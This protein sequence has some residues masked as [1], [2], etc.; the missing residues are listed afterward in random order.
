[1]ADPDHLRILSEGVDAWN[2]WRAEHLQVTPDLTHA[3]LRGADLR[4]ADL[5]K[6]NLSGA[7]LY[8]AN[9]TAA[10][11]KGSWLTAANLT[12]AVL[13]GANLIGAALDFAHLCR[14]DLTRAE[15]TPEGPPTGLGSFLDLAT[16]EGLDLATFSEPGFLPTYVARA[17]QYAHTPGTGDAQQWPTFIKVVLNRIKAV[18][19]LY[20]GIEPPRLI[21][22]VEAIT[23]ELIKYLARHPRA[24][25]RIGP[26]QF[27]EL[28]AEILASYGWRVQLTPASKDGGYDLFA[29]SKDASGLETSWIIECKKYKPENKVGVDIAR[30]LYGV[31]TDLSVSTALLATTSDF[32]RGVKAYKASHYDLELRDYEGILEWINTYRPNP[33]GRLYIKDDRL[34]LPGDKP[35]G[36]AARHCGNT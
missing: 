7:S 30:A 23:A 32:T 29:I 27:E 21:E 20:A 9:L 34:I 28:I 1:M 22:A 26:R 18:R 35:P 3:D 36:Q 17:F 15:F 31:K 24:L 10:N 33:D 11:L 14:A 5:S 6:T 19:N 25:Y 4:R 13:A 8:G 16:C 12:D 2:A